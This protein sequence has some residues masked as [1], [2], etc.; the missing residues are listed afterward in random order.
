MPSK[1]AK[2][3]DLHHK[4]SHFRVN[5]NTVSLQQ[6][7]LCGVFLQN[8]HDVVV[9]ALCCHMKR[10]HETADGGFKVNLSVNLGV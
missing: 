3:E 2:W 9:S 5:V 7:Y 4:S 1:A 10:R 6:I 8:L